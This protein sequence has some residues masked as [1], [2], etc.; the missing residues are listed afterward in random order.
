MIVRALVVTAGLVICTVGLLWISARPTGTSLAQPVVAADADA[1]MRGAAAFLGAGFGG[2]S[3]DALEANAVP[4]RLV[5]AALVLDEKKRDPATSIEL[6]TLDRVLARFG[7]LPDAQVTNLPEGVALPSASMPLG[8]TYGDVAPIGGAVIRVANLGCATC[9]AGVSYD[10]AGHPKPEMAVLGMPNSSLDLE[11][12]TT[13]VFRALRDFIDAPQLLQTVD[14]LYPNI[15]WRERASLRYLVL[16]L[17]RKRLQSLADSD[18]PLPFPN[19]SPG[20]TNGVAALKAALGTSLAGGGRDDAGVV[21]IPDL[22]HR[23]WRTTFLADGVYALPGTPSE[24]VEAEALDDAR[25]SRLAAIVTFFTVPSMGVHPDK[26]RGHLDDASAIMSFLTAYRPQDFPAPIDR[27]VAAGGRGIYASVCARCHGT[28]DADLE[29]PSLRSYP[30]WRGDVGTDPLR[31]QMFDRP[32]AAAVEVTPYADVIK[33]ERGKGYAAPPLTGLWASAPYLHN[34]SVPT[35]AALLSPH[36]R[37][38]RFMVGGHALDMNK[39]GIRLGED[40]AYP[41]GY[42]PFSK[43]AWIDTSSLGR[44]AGGHDFGANLS[45]LEKQQLIE[46]LK[47]L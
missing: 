29:A 11:A 33:V 14:A 28:Y 3:M 6:A 24:A 15:G 45:A 32:L 17:A 4:W 21:S 39:V 8:F 27:K 44:G 2:I 25:L 5:A 12:Y 20:S 10:A 18:R 38:D 46:Y 35:L 1:E 43:P 26:A 31:E 37:P 47:L 42:K 30:N 19:G 40:G 9:H 36:T 23:V 16:P 34:G 41:A 13:A 7:F 22:G